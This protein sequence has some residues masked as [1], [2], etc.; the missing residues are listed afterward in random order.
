[1]ELSVPGPHPG[2]GCELELLHVELSVPGPHPCVGC[3]AHVELSVPGPHPCVGSDAHVELSVPGPHPTHALIAE[4]GS[5]TI[6]HQFHHSQHLSM[7]TS[8]QSV[9]HH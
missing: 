9:I 4:F 3:D 8:A 5:V 2:V 7:K 6:Q 1:V